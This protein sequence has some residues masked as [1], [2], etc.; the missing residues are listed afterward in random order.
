MPDLN[1][2]LQLL[3]DRDGSDLHLHV[4]QPPIVRIHGALQ[5]TEFDPLGPEESEG[6]TL[7]LLSD[8]QR[9]E[10][11]ATGAVQTA[12]VTETARFRVTVFRQQGYVGGAFRLIPLAIRSLADLGLPTA[13]RD[14]CLRPQGLLLVGGPGGSGKSTTLAGLVQHINL[15]S[16]VHV[17]TLE[18]PIEFVYSDT[19]ASID[20]RQVGE[21][22]SS[23]A[24]GVAHAVRQNANVVVLSQLY[25]LE[26]IRAALTAAEAGCLVVAAVSTGSAWRTIERLIDSYATEDQRR[27]RSQIAGSIIGVISQTLLPR[28]DAPALAAAFGIMVG[29]LPIRNLIREGKVPQIQAEIESGVKSGMISLDQA[30][31]ALVRRD[32]VRH[33]DALAKA[34]NPRE[35]EQRVSAAVPGGV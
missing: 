10:L 13:A 20:Q 35:F 9:R 14:L 32:T 15:H 16:K 8:N 27:A 17:V 1:E 33:D 18:D 25:D 31:A 4:G 22:V 6:L 7:P 26:T 28:A 29:N 3:F 34:I 2:L 19:N 21:D 12:H 24:D 30:L 5:R 11:D 23:F